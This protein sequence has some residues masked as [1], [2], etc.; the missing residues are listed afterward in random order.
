APLE[1]EDDHYDG[2]LVAASALPADPAAFAARL[3]ASLAAW[4]AGGT[5][6]VWLRLGLAQSALIPLAV[7]Q[8][9]EFH[10]AEKD[11][12]MMTRW[13]PTAIPCTL[14][15]NASHQVGVGAFVV[16]SRHEVLVVQERSGVLR[17]KGVWK[18]PTGLVAAGED[19]TAA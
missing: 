7:A 10:H 8:G 11:H 9:F 1:A 5:R 16:N 13:L 19:F 18:M 4:E 3:R 12:L 2:K 14:P 17:G 15:A 6:G